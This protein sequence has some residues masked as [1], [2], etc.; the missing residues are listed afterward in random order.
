MPS[1]Y[2]HIPFCRKKCYYCSFVVA[3]AKE[4]EIPAYLEGLKKEAAIYSG[5]RV[6]T[7]YLGGGTPSCLSVAQMTALFTIIKTQFLFSP[8]AEFTVEINPEDLSEEKVAFLS[9]AGVN[10][11]SLG[12]QSFQDRNLEFL[13]RS[14]CVQQTMKAFQ[15][16]RQ[17]GFQNINLDLLFSLPQQT[18]QDINDE[19]KALLTLKSDHVS[20][21]SLTVEKPSRFSVQGVQLP[22]GHIQAEHYELVMDLLEQAGFRQYEISNFAKPGK[23]SLHNI[24]YWL[25]GEYIGL[26]VAAHTH[27][28]G[29]RTWNVTR[30]KDYIENIRRDGSA[31]AGSEQLEPMEK[32][33]ETML[34]G[35]RMNRGVDLQALQARGGIPLPEETHAKIQN[36]IDAGLLEKEGSQLKATR[37]GRLVLDEIAAALI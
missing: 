16:L 17:A 24:N 28:A 6:D 36:F 20:L 26:G 3:I 5:Q 18:R 10:R 25:G 27:L 29:K 33:K 13:G 32:L 7:V 11:V 8:S 30:L 31:V 2:I 12:A 14:H 1:L 4:R 37:P 34:F 9:A 19:S 23:E 21:Y 22:R 35:L 15:L